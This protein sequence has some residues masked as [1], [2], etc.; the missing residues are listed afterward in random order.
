MIPSFTNQ[1]LLPPGVHY[2]SWSEFYSRYNTNSYR[3]ELL[4]GLNDAIDSLRFAGCCVIYV[5]GSFVSNI[6]MPNDFDACWDLFGVD[7]LKLDPQLLDFSNGRASQ[8]TKYGGELFPSSIRANSDGALFL[9]FFQ[10]D[11]NLC[12]PKGIVAIK[13]N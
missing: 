9:D 2:S 10:M 1:G 5:D 6:D 3:Q 12:I 8:K 7:P 13:L 4:R 11:K